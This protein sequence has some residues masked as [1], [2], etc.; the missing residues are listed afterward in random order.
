MTE[1]RY[2]CN[3]F[4]ESVVHM[5]D[6]CDSWL[7][8]VATVL[9]LAGLLL[10]CRRWYVPRLVERHSA[11]LYRHPSLQLLLVAP[12]S[13]RVEDTIALYGGLVLIAIGTLVG[14]R[15]AVNRGLL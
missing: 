6:R 10:I 15:W 12:I 1:W 3:V 13:S 8:R 9:T 11:I 2:D 14:L 5:G 4:W 7:G